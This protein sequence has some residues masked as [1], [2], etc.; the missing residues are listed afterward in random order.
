M[1]Q[2]LEEAEGD[3]L[4][5]DAGIARAI[6]R[7]GPIRKKQGG[8]RPGI[9]RDGA[10]YA[11]EAGVNRS[12]LG[13]YSLPLDRPTSEV[14]DLPDNDDDD[15][16]GSSSS[17]L[18]PPPPPPPLLLLPPHLH[19]HTLPPILLHLVHHASFNEQL[20]DPQWHRIRVRPSPVKTSRPGST[21][22]IIHPCPN[23]LH[24]LR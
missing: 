23:H 16:D 13:I 15:D 5:D 24:H 21:C 3:F 6:D 18:P 22:P 1:E 12:S 10:D 11:E 14:P 8:E 20:L 2:I 9:V 17:L 4:S 19:L 7:F